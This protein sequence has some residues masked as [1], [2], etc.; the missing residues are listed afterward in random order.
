M[1]FKSVL[2]LSFLLLGG[3]A[4]FYVEP[5]LNEAKKSCKIEAAPVNSEPE[6]LDF[7]PGNIRVKKDSEMEFMLKFTEIAGLERM[8]DQLRSPVLGT[9]A[10]FGLKDTKYSVV[11]DLSLIK[12]NQILRF[13]ASCSASAEENPQ[14]YANSCKKKIRENLKNQINLACQKGIF[15]NF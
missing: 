9:E 14:N 1:K 13:S 6:D 10:I 8:S 7:T 15:E 11:A 4:E 12:N 2:F 3:C 5:E